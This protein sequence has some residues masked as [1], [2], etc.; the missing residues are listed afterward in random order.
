[1]ACRP[2]ATGD[3]RDRMMVSLLSTPAILGGV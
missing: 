1:M 2:K 3:T